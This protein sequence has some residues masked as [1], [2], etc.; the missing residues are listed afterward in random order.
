MTA[1]DQQ[2]SSLENEGFFLTEKFQGSAVAPNTRHVHD[3]LMKLIDDGYVT[4]VI[5]D[6][7]GQLQTVEIWAR[8]LS[9]NGGSSTVD[10]AA[11]APSNAAF[12]PAAFELLHDKQNSVDKA[13]GRLDEQIDDLAEAISE[14][15]VERTRLTKLRNDIAGNIALMQQLAS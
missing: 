12:S 6:N 8:P 7:E 2:R 9:K 11:P 1:Q 14:R 10:Q 13:I 15:V 3:R 4:A 5:R